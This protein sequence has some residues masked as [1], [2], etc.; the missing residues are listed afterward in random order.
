[1][2]IICCICGKKQSG[3]IKDYL[4]ALFSSGYRVCAE[5]NEY[6]EKIMNADSVDDV[7]TEIDYLK[8]KIRNNSEINGDVK[9]YLDNLFSMEN[10][11]DRLSKFEDA[12]RCTI[13]DS[14]V[15]PFAD[16]CEN[17]GCR[18]FINEL[19]EDVKYEYDIVTVDNKLT[20]NINKDKIKK[21]IKHYASHGWRLHTIYT[22]ELG[23]NAIAPFNATACEDVL[24]F[25]KKVSI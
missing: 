11:G 17:C 9:E 25:E 18:T 15:D 6:Y 1:M 16:T 4:L 5:C 21:I 19:E 8:D 3:W 20:G 23:K 24:V 12:V 22:N 14:L 13:C 2:G 7:Q 10:S